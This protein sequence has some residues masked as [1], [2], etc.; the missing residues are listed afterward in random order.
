MRRR[1][2][3]SPTNSAA[4]ARPATAP[5]ASSRHRAR[6]R[7][8]LSGSR[9]ARITASAASDVTRRSDD[10]RRPCATGTFTCSECHSHACAHSEMQH[11][12]V[13]GYQCTDHKCYE[14]HSS[15]L[16]SARRRAGRALRGLGW[17]GDAAARARKHRRRGG[18]CKR[19]ARGS[20]AARAA[21][22]SPWPRRRHGRD[23]PRST[24][25]SV[26]RVQFVTDHR[27][28]L[29]RGAADGLVVGQ[30][31]PIARGVRA[32]GSCKIEGVGDHEATCIGARL[33]VGDA[34]RTPRTAAKR[35]PPAPALPP[36]STR[37][38]WRRARRWSPKHHRQGRFQRQ[39]RLSHARHR[40]GDAGV[41]G[42]V[43][44][45]RRGVAPT[46]RNELTASSAASRSAPPGFASTARSR[47]C[48]GPRPLERFRAETPTQFY[49]WEAEASRRLQEGGTTPPSAACGRITRRG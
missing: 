17:S 40:R 34:F 2:I 18:G 23:A 16:D 35:W 47:R 19:S 8:V 5:S 29:D 41:R 39:A 10:V 3:T 49:L 13:M 28:Y 26:R 14:C 36:S 44:P 25:Q 31:L 4:S 48:A 42:L 20:G 33:R 21:R 1:S 6:A 15:A 38:R 37:R 9:R 45:A 32:I 12:N 30:W 11:K 7:H 43:H 24:G 27:A 22:R 46:C